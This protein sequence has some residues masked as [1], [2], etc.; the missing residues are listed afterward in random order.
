MNIRRIIAGITAV[1]IIGGV[2]PSVAVTSDNAVITAIA[3]DYTDGT[4]GHLIYKN[5][6]TTSIFQTVTKLKRKSLFRLKLRVCLLQAL[7]NWHF[8][9]VL[10]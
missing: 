6:G 2:M 4:Y 5:Y 3:A 1:C 8:T 7:K 10:L 9:V